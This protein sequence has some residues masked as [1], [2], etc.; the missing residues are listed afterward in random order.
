MAEKAGF[1]EQRIP[2]E[3]HEN[4]ACGDQ[5]K[6]KNE[7]MPREAIAS[8]GRINR[9]RKAHSRQPDRF[10]KTIARC[11]TIKESEHSNM[12]SAQILPDFGQKLRDRKNA[13]RPNQPGRLHSER[14]ESHQVNRAQQAQKKPTGQLVR[15]RSR[16]ESPKA[17][18]SRGKP[19]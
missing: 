19:S 8:S 18:W 15:G 9:Q 4:L 13:A 16:P 12:P 17:I 14:G 11:R 10:N 6:I 3:A 7:E 5:R 2:L 1:K